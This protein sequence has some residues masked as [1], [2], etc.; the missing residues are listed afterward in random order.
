MQFQLTRYLT[1]PATISFCI[2]TTSI[3]TDVFTWG[4]MFQPNFIS[5]MQV[6][7]ILFIYTMDI[8]YNTVIDLILFYAMD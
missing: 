1:P 2:E 6:L 5:I 7:P 3:R 8:P 4:V